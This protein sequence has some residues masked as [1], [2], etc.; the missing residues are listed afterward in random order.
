MIDRSMPRA[1]L[2]ALGKLELPCVV[3]CD[4]AVAAAELGTADRWQ[5]VTG[6]NPR[7]LDR[8]VLNFNAGRLDGIAFT[9]AIACMG[10]RVLGAKT[11]GLSGTASG[12]AM[13]QAERRCP[14]ARVVLL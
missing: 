13:A 14:G 12:T 9:Y 2:D 6:A 5:S 8:A 3:F 7:E 11:V 10:F 1:T 4:S